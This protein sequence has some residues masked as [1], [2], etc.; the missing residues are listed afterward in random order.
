MGGSIIAQIGFEETKI[1]FWKR[2]RRMKEL[3]ESRVKSPLN[4]YNQIKSER[5]LL[6]NAKTRIA[7]NRIRKF[8]PTSIEDQSPSPIPSKMHNK[9]KITK[10]KT[11]LGKWTKNLK[12]Q[13]RVSHHR[14]R[15]R[16]IFL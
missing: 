1:D 10:M 16:S 11:T 13:P 6:I 12:P 7:V 3:W 15:K 2:S 5:T 4:F 9:I 8:L 14:N